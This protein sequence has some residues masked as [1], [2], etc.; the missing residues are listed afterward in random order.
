M[1]LEVM[2]LNFGITASWLFSNPNYHLEQRL[3]VCFVLT[4]QFFFSFWASAIFRPGRVMLEKKISSSVVLGQMLLKEF[5]KGNLL[6][7]RYLGEMSDF[8]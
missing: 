5:F 7:K 1:I 4:T 6:S 3:A 8:D 2:L